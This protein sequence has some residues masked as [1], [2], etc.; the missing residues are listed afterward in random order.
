MSPQVVVVGGGFAGVACT[1]LLARHDVDVALVDKNDYHQF[2]PLLYQLATAQIAMADVAH[3]LRGLFVRHPSARVLTGEVTAVDPEARSVQVAEGPTLSAEHLVLAAG[4]RPEFFG[5][6]GAE[7]HAF[8]L[9]SVDDAER[10]RSRIISGLDAVDRDPSLVD[11]GGLTIVIVGGGPTGVEMAG[12]LAETLRDVVPVAY[13]ELPID[14]R[15]VVLVDHGE[16]LLKPFSERAHRYAAERLAADGVELQ[17]GV[18]V[19]EVTAGHV[20]LSDGARI[21]TRLCIWAGGERAAGIVADSGLPTG[22]GG[23]VDVQPDLSV[24][25]FPGVWAV[26]DAANVPGEDG[27]ALPQL[28]SVAQQSGRWV[29]RNVLADLRGEPRTPF[30]YHDKGI[31]AMVGRNAAVA[32]L[33][34]A[35][36]EI[37]G[38]MAFAAWLGVHAGLLEGPRQKVA[39]LMSWGWDYASRRRPQALVDRPDAAVIDWD[40]D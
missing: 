23:R 19:T 20:T 21:D 30:D 6:P 13:R 31:M 16:A 7:E 2:Q 29:A 32:E 37:D 25:G 36:H 27:H 11:R 26:G 24:S 14:R 34:A 38:P 12:A 28:G 40:A 4:A 22:R 35:R 9:Y 18:G 1:K 10:L 8:P 17:L 15:R 33:G 5:T 39:A 3:P